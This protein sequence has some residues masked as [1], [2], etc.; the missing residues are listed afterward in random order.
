MAGKPHAAGSIE[1]SL[2]EIVWTTTPHGRI[3]WFNRRWYEYTGLSYP[4]DAKVNVL[5]RLWETS[6]HPDDR[7][8]TLAL[9]K[10]AVSDD[11]PF[12]SELRLRGVDGDYRWFKLHAAR[13]GSVPV[14]WIGVCTDVDEAHRR[15]QRLAFMAKAGE[16]LAE[17]LDQQRTLYRLLEI[18]VPEFGDWAAIDLLDEQNRLKT[19]AAIHADPRRASIVRLLCDRY[20]LVP[21]YEEHVIDALRTRRPWILSEIPAELLERAAAPAL[22]R[23]IRA[24]K[25]RSTVTVPLR[26]R[27]RT[28]GSLVAYWA[29]TQRRYE[30]SDVPL[31]EELAKRAATA[32]ENARLYEREHEVAKEF[33][34][35]ALPISLPQIAGMRFHGIYV[36]GSAGAQVGGDW[37]DALQLSDGRIVISIGDVAGTGLAAAVIMSS[38]RQ[39]IRGVAQVYAGPAAML[40]AAD[41]TLKVE[42]P[43][44]FVTAFVAVFD[45]VAQT[46]TYAVAG[47]PPPFVRGASGDVKALE[48]S[49]LPLGLRIRGDANEIVAEIQPKSL[50][51]FY[52]DG[53]I[54]SQRDVVSGEQ[55]LMAAIRRGKVA[56][57]VNPAKALYDTIIKDGVSD[58]VVILTMQFDAPTAGSVA[59]MASDRMHRWTFDSTDAETAGSARHEFVRALEEGGACSEDL[60]ASELVFGELIGN[61]VRY[62]PGTIEVMLDWSAATPVLHVLDRGAGF[63]FAPRL[64]TDLLSERGRGL[65]IVWSLSEDLNVTKRFDGGSH[66][67]AV[68]SVRRTGTSTQVKPAKSL[69]PA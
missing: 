46:L 24:L 49:G 68:L 31:F 39:V 18:I 26:T 35:A 7:D 36:P 5:E 54:E 40:D 1:D 43:D 8:R 25:P 57:S 56:A 64:P 44:T 42:Y 41:R 2:P 14:R 19:V 3:N 4:E 6:V 11:R 32:I 69:Y 51:V 20:N 22:L 47:H 48:G 16:V 65:F 59:A 21:E 52:T 28:L 63:V 34:R 62:A 33:Q 30:E 13:N 12:T 61:V 37:Y 45:R 38:M 17:S 66:A 15:A 50:L 23:V 58:D 53:L 60:Y 67:R 9:R 29:E 27:D 55:R 10:N